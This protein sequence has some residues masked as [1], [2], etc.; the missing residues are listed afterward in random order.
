M[1]KKKPAEKNWERRKLLTAEE[2]D[3]RRQED[4]PPCKSGMAQ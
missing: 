3:R 1:A 2:T 4:Y